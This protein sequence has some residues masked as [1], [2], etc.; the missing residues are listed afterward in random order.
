MLNVNQHKQIIALVII[1]NK[2]NTIQVI[3]V[4]RNHSSNKPNLV[5]F[6]SNSALALTLD[7]SDFAIY[8]LITESIAH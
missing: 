1:F 4:I 5:I 7:L 6:A 8:G 2:L 3:C